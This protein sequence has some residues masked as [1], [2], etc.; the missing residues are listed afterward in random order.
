MEN[1]GRENKT[2]TMK[3]M[4]F[5]SFI[6]S[7]FI[8]LVIISSLFIQFQVAHGSEII[9]G[10]GRR[11]GIRRPWFRPP[12]PVGGLNKSPIIRPP[13]AGCC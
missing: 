2:E 6:G 10:R 4:K 7:F 12:S 9:D 3:K 8:T 1:T 11:L 5:S 13:P